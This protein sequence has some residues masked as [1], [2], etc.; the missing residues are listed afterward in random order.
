MNKKEY[1][2]SIKAEGEFW[3]KESRNVCRLG[4]PLSLDYRN[5]SNISREKGAYWD[6]CFLDQ[7]VR[8][9]YRKFVIETA[10]KAGY[11]ALDL[12]CGTGWLS[13]ELARNGLDVTGMDVSSDRIKIATNYAET[14]KII[15]PAKLTYEVTDLNEIVLGKEKYDVVTSWDGLH[16]VQKSERLVGQ[17]SDCLKS[18]GK[19]VIFESLNSSPINAILAH[20]LWFVLPNKKTIAYKVGIVIKRLRGYTRLQ[21]IESSPFEGVTGEEL[22]KH[23]QKHL[24][25]IHHK[26]CLA[27]LPLLAGSFSYEKRIQRWS[28]YFIKYLDT[29]VTSIGL[30][31][32]SY[33][34]LIAQKR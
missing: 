11:K 30:L 5:A 29:I 34:L 22:I 23:I 19:L 25:L 31:R 27:L 33:H 28:L 9:K 7:F 24:K 6:D 15:P 18:G 8:G 10:T 13:L 1:L 26:R 4:I 32:G 12:C 16:H 21:H 2:D 3:G 14:Q 20:I 17:I